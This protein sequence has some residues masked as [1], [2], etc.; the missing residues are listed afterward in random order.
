MKKALLLASI[1]L[2]F[3]QKATT[4][5]FAVTT[6]T[7]VTEYSSHLSDYTDINRVF[8]TLLS[9]D[10]RDVYEALLKVEISGNGYTIKSKSDV[11]SGEI[12]TLFK[13]TPQLLTGMQLQHIFN[14]DQ[15]DFIGISRENFLRTGGKLPEG[16]I[17][18]CFT[19]YDINRLESVSNVFCA[20]GNVSVYDPPQIL[21]PSEV[22]PTT[23]P[24]NIFFSWMPMHVGAFPVEYTLEIYEDNLDFGADVVVNNTAPIFTKNLPLT[25]YLYTEFDPALV[26]GQRYLMRVQIRDAIGSATFDNQGWSAIESFIYGETDVTDGTGGGTCAAP[27]GLAE[28]MNTTEVAIS[29]EGAISY[30]E[31]QNTACEWMRINQNDQSSPYLLNSF[32]LGDCSD[33]PIRICRDC[34]SGQECTYLPITTPDIDC[35]IPQDPIIVQT[36]STS[37]TVNWNAPEEVVGFL[38]RYQPE[39]ED[40]NFEQEYIEGANSFTMENLE[41]N[42]P[43]AIEICTDCTQNEA[44]RCVS[45]SGHTDSGNTYVGNC[46]PPSAIEVTNVYETGFDI[47]WLTAN[48]EIRYTVDYALATEGEPIWYSDQ[49]LINTHTITGLMPATQYVFRVCPQCTESTCSELTYVTTTEE[50]DDTF[51]IIACGESYDSYLP[52]SSGPAFSGTLAV[53]DVVKIADFDMILS[54]V[55]ENNFVY[56]G[57]GV[58]TIPFGQKEVNVKFSN[59]RINHKKEVYSGNVFGIPDNPDPNWDIADDLPPPLVLGG[60]ICQEVVTEE[61]FDENGIWQP[62]GEPYDPNGFG[63]DGNYAV[64][65]PYPGYEPGD[66]FDPQY[67]PNGFD[68][69][70][71]HVET[72]TPFNP[73]GCNQMGLTA[74]GQPCNQSGQGPYYWIDDD[75]NQGPVTEAGTTFA[76]QIEDDK[77]REWI[78]EGL[79]ALK[80]E[81]EAKITSLRE[82]CN[83]L[84]EEMIDL[85]EELKYDR[86]FIFGEADQ[87][88]NEGC[89]LEFAHEPL[90]LAINVERNPDAEALENKHILLYHKDKEIY[91]HLHRIEIIMNELEETALDAS[92]EELRALMQRFTQEEV[93]AFNADHPDAI[94]A[95]VKEQM[96]KKVEEIYSAL[97]GSDIGAIILPDYEQ[98]P[99]ENHPLDL[100]LPQFKTSS[101]VAGNDISDEVMNEILSEAFS[102]NQAEEFQFQYDQGWTNVN[103]V[104]RAFIL[105]RIAKA[106]AERFPPEGDDNPSNT[107]IEL[108][109]EVLGKTYTMLLDNIRF[110]PTQA[111]LDVYMVLELPNGKKMAFSTTDVVFNPGGP[112]EANNL[113][114]ATDIQIRMTNAARLNIRAS[115]NTYVAFN[116]EGFDGMGIDA[117]IEF[118]RKYLVPLNPATMKPKPDP[119][120]VQVEFQVDMPAWGEFI[121]DVNIDPFA[122]AGREDVHWVV[123][124]ATLDFSES[125]TPDYIEFPEEYTSPYV[126]NGH[127]SGLWKGFYLQELSVH[128][129]NELTGG[130]AVDGTTMGVRNVIIDDRGFTG[131][132][133]ISPLLS[134]ERGNLNGW[135]FSIDELSVNVIANQFHSVKFSGSIN[136]PLFKGEDSGNDD[137]ITAA[138][139]FGYQA[140]IRS[141]N[142]YHFT[143]SPNSNKR[144]PLFLATATLK[145]NTVITI[146]KSED[147][148][149]AQAK[150][151]G[152]LTIGGSNA[153]GIKTPTITFENL[154]FR[155]KASYFP[156]PASSIWGTTVSVGA[157]FK[158]FGFSISNIGMQSI[159]E[160][161]PEDVGLNL[162]IMLNL[163]PAN[164]TGISACAGLLLVGRMEMQN[165]RQKWVYD[166]LKVKKINVNAS[167]PGFTIKACLEFFDYDPTEGSGS[168]VEMFG[169][170][171]KGQASAW[172]RGAN[173]GNNN[174]PTEGDESENENENENNN[175]NNNNTT[176]SCTCNPVT[177][178][179]EGW[180]FAAMAIF[181]ETVLDDKEFNYFM[182][183]VMVQLPGEGIPIGPIF[184]NGFGGGVFKHMRRDAPLQ[185]ALSTAP[186][187]TD[188]P[189][190]PDLGQSLS[191][192]IFTPDPDLGLGIKAT[193]AISAAKQEAFN[194]NVTFEIQF[195]SRDEDGSGGGINYIALYGNC[196]FMIEP[197]MDK[198][199][200]FDSTAVNPNNGAKISAYFDLRFDFEN[201]VFHAGFDVAVNAL[202]G[203]LTGGGQAVIHFAPDEWYINVGWPS[204]N[205]QLDQRIKLYYDIP[206]IG[207]STLT[208]YLD[209]GQNIPTMP[210]PPAYVT[211]MTGAGNFMAN[212]SQ[213]ASGRG[214]AFGAAFDL[215]TGRKKFLIFYA[216]FHV[217]VGFDINIQDYGDAQCYN[218]GEALGINGWYASGQA[219]AFVEGA[220]GVEV[221]LWFVHGEFEILSIG[222]AAIL[223]AKLPNP[224]WARG[225]VGG[226][227]SI[228]GGLVEGQCNFQVTMGEACQM[229]GGVDPYADFPLILDVTPEDGLVVPTDITPTAN[230]FVGIDQPIETGEETYTPRLE[231]ARLK[232]KN[233]GEEIAGTMELN[234]NRNSLTFTPD[235]FLHQPARYI[236]E[237]KVSLINSS[238]TE[239]TSEEQRTVFTCIQNINYL[240]EANVKASYPLDNQLNFYKEE[241][242]AQEGYILLKRDQGYL[243][244]V[245]ASWEQIIR[246]T[247][248]ENT[249]IYE[250]ELTYSAAEKKVTFDLP[251][252]EL[253]NGAMYKM[254]I[255]NRIP[256]S[257]ENPTPAGESFGGESINDF[258]GSDFILGVGTTTYAEEVIYSLVFRVST[259]NTFFEKAEAIESEMVLQSVPY[260]QLLVYDTNIQEPFDTYETKGH[261]DIPALVSIESDLEH[262]AWYTDEQIATIYQGL[263][264]SAVDFDCAF[265]ITWRNPDIAGVPPRESSY[266]SSANYFVGVTDSFF[267]QGVLPESITNLESKLKYST[268]SFIL[269]DIKDLAE[270]AFTAD[271][272]YNGCYSGLWENAGSPS[273]WFESNW[274]EAEVASEAEAEFLELIYNLQNVG[275]IEHGTYPVMLRY[276]LPGLDL[277]TSELRVELDY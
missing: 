132:A 150:L 28:Q 253:E 175:N 163:T 254:E 100:G 72:G 93:D 14:P 119:E 37:I 24:Q 154:L 179:G 103:G 29:W 5:S 141:G 266:L 155:N 127:A 111:L 10:E 67:D 276:S 96:N 40:A 114:L 223:Q 199:A 268:V 213:R 161:T 240:S 42:T 181:G 117:S 246:F 83:T 239:V 233:T 123:Q 70:G 160:G 172:F 174:T 262:T 269:N 178:S 167:A 25:S 65:P 113:G 197:N 74:D 15:L 82:T 259:Y 2:F 33:M 1:F 32:Y 143:V 133:F 196:G 147:E 242:D 124:H 229:Q 30:L 62:S 51:T 81:H 219:W 19:V 207:Q 247:N 11:L 118:C 226:R 49:D 232:N 245:P 271:N 173:D 130:E 50:D 99:I 35:P 159:P 121:V 237:V 125:E 177:A 122:V 157:N 251:A 148:F 21:T 236:F 18:I 165:E 231:Y 187:P 97:Y 134:L 92:V 256:Q 243:F 263:A 220:I 149:I 107:P 182:V 202:N 53:G 188:D 215:D 241:Y 270:Q 151:Y 216:D 244:N 131:S 169:T 104:H 185:M 162:D 58:I 88:I 45:L 22:V 194:A 60:E 230:F 52:P 86:L 277:V 225:A 250:T 200:D 228:L 71:N 94:K 206:L 156:E 252:A 76:A 217:G 192:A 203:G 31:Y 198:N 190:L 84:R 257:T 26:T 146:Q 57:Q 273:N 4:Q 66:P 126:S 144:I 79:N 16:P 168:G 47:S 255:I 249:S 87:Y 180:G 3:A 224:F 212:E 48:D 140:E 208:A 17:S 85:Q 205:P 235:E 135:A 56:S 55:T 128:L 109:K 267:D 116:C 101:L 108:K 91:T 136:I 59:I 176:Q 34:A 164:K 105:E 137:E 13:N 63:Q 6:T 39:D 186:L 41:E 120:R 204:D 80:A 27:D 195:N 44:P 36:T 214:F 184:L 64:V 20:L 142:E 106:R 98:S 264:N 138:D 23:S 210:S 69:D 152:S 171:F 258:L 12:V 129:P 95:W 7:Q 9:T 115:E 211:A 158:N 89:H 112:V 248:S 38:I 222:A 139:C 265:E 43:Y 275:Q 75:D 110:S 102:L 54:S 8:V 153:P 73:S 260:H 145:N 170:G 191:G 183:D 221:N 193:V 234:P 61:G 274:L 201:D 261:R 238:G 68:A 272:S 166:H 218:T 78:I 90:P 189:P 46:N 209:F 227:Y 77:L